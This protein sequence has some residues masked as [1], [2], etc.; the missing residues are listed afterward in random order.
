MVPVSVLRHVL[1]NVVYH[2]REYDREWQGVLEKQ[3]YFS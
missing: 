3:A 2:V 1:L